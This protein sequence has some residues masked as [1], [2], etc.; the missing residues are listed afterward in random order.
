VDESRITVEKFLTKAERAE[1]E[2]KRLKEE[3]RLRLL[4]A[5]DSGPRALVE[6][7]NGTL[8][9]KKDTFNLLTE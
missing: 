1:L 2:A 9:V 8:E 5:D 7:M 3:E 4:N 6:M